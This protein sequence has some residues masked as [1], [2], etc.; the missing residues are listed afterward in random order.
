MKTIAQIDGEAVV[1]QDKDIHVSI[2]PNSLN[3]IIP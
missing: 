1:L 3:V 2:L